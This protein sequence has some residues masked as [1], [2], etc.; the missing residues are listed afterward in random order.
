MQQVDLLMRRPEALADLSRLSGE[1]AAVLE[2]IDPVR[3]EAVHKTFAS[4]VRARWWAARFPA[5]LAT[6]DHVLGDALATARFLIGSPAFERAE[7][8]DLTGEAL[9]GALLD[10]LQARQLEAPP[11]LPELLAYEYLLSTGLPRRGRREAVSAE[12]EARLLGPRAVWL[13]GGRLR[14]GILLCT[15]EWPVGALQEEP[16]DAEPDPTELLFFLEAED[17][18]ELEPPGLVADVL[19]LL[20]GD[21]EDAVVAGLGDDAKEALAW[22]K[23]LELVA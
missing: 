23:E 14:R 8:E 18:V 7:G 20:T 12:L 21:V 2:T 10:A 4:L 22:L 6:L 19:E 9:C 17:V 5:V 11:W 1:D 3:L 13:R 16:H 15:F